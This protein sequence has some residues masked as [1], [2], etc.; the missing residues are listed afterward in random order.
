MLRQLGIRS[1]GMMNVGGGGGALLS[2]A[3]PGVRFPSADTLVPSRRRTDKATMAPHRLASLMTCC[4]MCNL[5][6]LRATLEEQTACMQNRCSF[7][8]CNTVWM[9]RTPIPSGTAQSGCYGSWATAQGALHSHHQR[10]GARP[11][12]RC[13][14]RQEMHGYLQQRGVHTSYTILAGA[15]RDVNYPLAAFAWQERDSAGG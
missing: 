15:H 5:P 13:R 10:R 6:S 2:T 14:H 4:D 9:E 11:L 8:G 3:L 12:C 7:S 1:L